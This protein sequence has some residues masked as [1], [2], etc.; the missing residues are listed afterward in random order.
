MRPGDAVPVLRPLAP[1]D[2]EVALALNNAAVPH[3]NGLEPESFD[4][5][6]EEAYAARVIEGP[7]GSL[8]GLL[9]VYAPGTA[10]DSANYRW[11]CAHFESFLYIDRIVIAEVARGTGAGRFFYQHL[12]RLG[13][14]AGIPRLVCEVNVDPPNP[15]SIAFHERLG[16]HG[17][18]D[19]ANPQSGKTVRYFE[20]PLD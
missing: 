4:A 15:G 19:V 5:L 6:I 8:L 12:E 9:V 1:G 2:H 10:Y 17:I 16:F 20:K 11:L 18:E 7:D 3:V 13:R 14:E